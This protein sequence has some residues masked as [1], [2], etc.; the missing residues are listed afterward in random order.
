[1]KK[2]KPRRRTCKFCFAAVLYIS[3]LIFVTAGPAGAV[4][5]PGEI[6]I[7]VNAGSPDSIRL[8]KLY[9]ELRRIP[10]GQI[11]EIK[12]PFQDNISRT[13]Y[14]ELIAAP[15]RRT[16]NNL[17][18]KGKRIRCIVTM[19]GVPLR[20]LLI[21][22][23]DI[24]EEKV[25]R[26][27]DILKQ[28]KD[29]LSELKEQPKWWD[30]FFKKSLPEKNIDQLQT[31]INKR[32]FELDHLKGND[33][34]AAVDSELALLLSPSYEF[35][36]W[37][38]NPAFIP[39]KD[40]IRNKVRALMVSRIDAPSPELVEKMIRTAVDV[41]KKGLS[42][43]IYLDARGLSGSSEYARFDDDIRRTAD[44]L[45]KGFMPV[46]LDNRPE[47]FGP[48]EAPDAALYCGWYSLGEY[49]DAFEWVKG[50]VGYHVASSE[51]VS[52]HDPARKYWVKSMLEKGVIASVG[53]VTEPY[54][55]AF[56]PPSIF[57]QLLM[58]GQYSLVEVFAMTNP[59]LSWRMI[60]VGD[61]LY[62]P[63]RIK[64]AYPLKDPPPPP[65]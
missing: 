62:N 60:L 12:A 18:D 58:S 57:F 7:V 52:L 23:S 17:Q 16:I 4:L 37:Q 39:F 34:V 51:A 5:K 48:G 33:T 42:G 11:A 30:K 65:L 10:H 64:P 54:L 19:Y 6:L 25:K 1:M 36:G 47:L 29:E 40:R 44:V 9:A 50:A 24:S 46:V 43:K 22:P 14:D 35:A 2:E 32:Q 38:P 13:Q 59:F 8:G 27:E 49:M 61:P 21:K 15:L 20:I 63:F 31:E 41:E 26:Y 3:T 56:P 53:P 45:E 28:K 55:I